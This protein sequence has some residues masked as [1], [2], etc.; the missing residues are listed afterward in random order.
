MS[1]VKFNRW[2]FPVAS[3]RGNNCISRSEATR[4]SYNN[5]MMPYALLL[6]L[7]AGASLIGTV[8]QAWYMPQLVEAKV[9][10]G[11]ADAA[12]EA[13]LARKEASVAKDMGDVYRAKIAALEEINKQL[14]EQSNGR[15][16]NQ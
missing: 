9:E 7:L 3:N 2:G 14:K 1:E 13:K 4:N 12:A 10:A 8:L 16:N 11:V 5:S 6:G 15:T